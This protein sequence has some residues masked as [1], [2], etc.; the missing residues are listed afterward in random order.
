MNKSKTFNGPLF[1]VG[2]S[3]SGTKLI[4][5]LLNRN[6]KVSLPEIESHFIPEMLEDEKMNLLESYHAIHKTSFVERFS[7]VKWPSYNHLNSI[8]AFDKKSD[9][10]ESVLKYYALGKEQSL[11]S[12]NVIW[13]DKTPSYL[14][15]L[16][17]LKHHYPNCK[18]V[19]IIRDP[20]DRALS[21]NKT[22]GKS[23][24]RATELW[25]KEIQNSEKWKSQP[26]TYFELKYE[27]LLS[28]TSDI[29]QRLCDFL[30]IGFDPKMMKLNKPSEKHGD[31][32]EMLKV[33]KSNSSKFES[34]KA[35]QI[36][37]IEE[38]AFPMMKSTGYEIKYAERHNPFSS[39]QMTAFKFIDFVNFK[40]SNKRKGY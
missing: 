26:E 35:N 15:H 19:H 28:D 29:L 38:I 16:D 13:G 3:R 34:M 25:R 30:D 40:I 17:L 36:K 8:S 32:S 2:L 7:E 10:M 18:F 33:R 39:I 14:R 5:D 31:S 12:E 22:W 20:R 9:L 11:W 37:R 4:R 27:D 21:V 24:F 1:I 6:D 23:M